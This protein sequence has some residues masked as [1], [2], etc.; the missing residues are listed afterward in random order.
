[1]DVSD[2]NRV[3]ALRASEKL[4]RG[5]LGALTRTLDA[6]V[7]E[8]SPDRLPEVVLRTIAQE[9]DAADITVWLTDDASA[10]V[11]F[12]FQFI[13]DRLFTVADA[14]HPAARMPPEARD[15]PVWRHIRT[16]K[17]PDF[18][19]DV[20]FDTSVPFREYNLSLGIVTILVVP[21]LIAGDVA[22]L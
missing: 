14:R 17:R 5:Q 12:A 11:R 21:M 22:G 20:R 15:N 3:Q 16:T 8:A 10:S 18:C 1:M 19:V 4:A 7:Q 2:R 13:D 6:L 9:F